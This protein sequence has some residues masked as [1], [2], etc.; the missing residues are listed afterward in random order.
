MAEADTQL[1]PQPLHRLT[2]SAAAD[3]IGCSPLSL[4]NAAWRRRHDIPTLRLGRLVM[5]NRLD[6]DLWLAARRE[7]RGAA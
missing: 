3:H 1:D 7:P 5:F 2:L 6:L 4:G